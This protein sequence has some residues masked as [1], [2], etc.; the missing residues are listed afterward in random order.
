[1]FVV[2]EVWCMCVALAVGSLL[3]SREADTY[4]G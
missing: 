2:G 1:M 3:F 4:F